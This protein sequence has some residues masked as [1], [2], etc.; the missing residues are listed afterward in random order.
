MASV[1]PEIVGVVFF[2]VA[3]VPPSIEIN[4]ATMMNVCVPAAAL[5]AGSMIVA[6]ATWVPA[7]S[8]FSGDTVQVP[9]GPI[10]VV[11]V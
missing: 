9:S 10:V 4:T 3:L 5:P 1:V 2:V 6:V 11:I 8:G 7:L